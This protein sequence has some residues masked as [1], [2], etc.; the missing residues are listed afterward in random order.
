MCDAA[1]SPSL[2][3]CKPG[4]LVPGPTCSS[5]YMCVGSIGGSEYATRK[6][7]FECAPGTVFS[8]GLGVC[9]HAYGSNCLSGLPLP[10]PSLL[11]FLPLPLPQGHCLP[12]VLPRLWDPQHPLQP[13]SARLRVLPMS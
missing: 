3:K 5:F 7:K 10:S 11:L 1:G 8:E 13:L 6:V 12:P 2:R 9:V 4:E